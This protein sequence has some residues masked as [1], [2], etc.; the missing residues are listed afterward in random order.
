MLK[1]RSFCGVCYYDDDQN[2]Q[3]LNH[4][5]LFFIVAPMAPHGQFKFVNGD[6]ENIETE[7]A[8]P[9]ARHANLFKDVKSTW[10]AATTM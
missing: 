10:M 8:V 9:A 3:C 7:P 4:H 2:Q 5:W 6:P 1:S